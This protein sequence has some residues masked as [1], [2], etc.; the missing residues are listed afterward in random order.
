MIRTAAALLA[1]TAAL[2]LAPRGAQAQRTFTCESRHGHREVCHVDT[3]GG[4]RL[5]DRLSDSPCIQGRTWGVARNGVWVDDGCR[6]RFR[7]GDD[8]RY[9][10]GGRN[11]YDGGSNRGGWNDYGDARTVRGGA[12]QCQ[13]AVADR[14]GVSRSRID[15][16]VAN[17]RG[18]DR[19]YG[20][21]GAGR[22]GTC[23]VDRNGHLSVRW[24]R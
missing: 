24:T 18:R 14:L 2:A 9:G 19:T 12:R 20:W 16:W 6:A 8:T 1:V 17:D 13:A 10:R 15:T 22:R 23:R 3:R 7:V 11:G 21:S 4:V 5:V